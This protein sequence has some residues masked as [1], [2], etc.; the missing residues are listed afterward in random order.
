MTTMTSP[1]SRS[2]GPDA[3]MHSN[4]RRKRECPIAIVYR[5]L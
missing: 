3:L 1:S 4:A 5:K 2:G